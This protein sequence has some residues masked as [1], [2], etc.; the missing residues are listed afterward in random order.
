MRS[1]QEADNAFYREGK[2]L[3]LPQDADSYYLGLYAKF[4]V[5]P[6]PLDRN[7]ELING[8][9]SGSNVWRWW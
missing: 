4:Y 1:W 3:Y 7:L 5:N 8:K 2:W 9:Q 6:T